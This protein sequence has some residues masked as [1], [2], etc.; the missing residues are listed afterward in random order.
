L[1]I[2]PDSLEIPK[3]SSKIKIPKLLKKFQASWKTFFRNSL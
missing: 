1:I 3:L 2:I